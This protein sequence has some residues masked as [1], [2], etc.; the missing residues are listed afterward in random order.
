MTPDP[1]LIADLRTLV[2]CESPSA[3]LEATAACADVVDKLALDRI[4]SVADRIVVDGRTHMRWAFGEP[5][6]LLLGHLDTVWPIGTLARWPFEVDGDRATGP[7][8]F[9][10][11]A[12]LAQM[13][14]TLSGRSSL[15][16]IAILV[17]S[18]EE[19]GST[20]S[21]ELIESTAR[22]LNAVLVLEPSAHGALKTARK[23]VGMFRV[24]VTGRAAHA[25]LE[26]ENGIN[27]TVEAAHQTL[28]IA[29]LGRTDLGTSVTPTVVSGGTTVN[30][31]PAD[32]VVNIDVRART[33][34]EMRRVQ[35][36]LEALKPVLPG[37]AVTVNAIGVR[38]PLESTMSDG[39]FARAVGHARRL[40]LD[41][42]RGVEVGGGSD[43][44]IT[45]A[46]GVPTLDGL[47]AVGDNAHAEGEW[48]SLSAMPERAA[49]VAALVDELLEA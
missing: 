25:G 40:G 27:A 42:L 28:A 32:A 2:E 4:G 13:F 12:G 14:A 18:D 19:I 10:M 46:I 6:V 16:G 37:A 29:A 9:D 31:V 24:G 47:G 30:T 41:E 33:V 48:V 22:G 17:T 3:D 26:P 11:K 8:A 38:A 44:N 15:D 5:K 39:L 34:A 7:G 1:Q 35:S 45:A 23:G 20:T 43:G 21:T 36:A 49:L